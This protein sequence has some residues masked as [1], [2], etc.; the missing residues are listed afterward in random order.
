MRAT[1]VVAMI[2]HAVADGMPPALLVDLRVLRAKVPQVDAAAL[3]EVQ[4]YHLA[5]LQG[6]P[7]E[8]AVGGC[9]VCAPGLAGC[10]R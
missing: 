7:E 1:A 2:R 6:Q 10:Q 9:G 3:E 4:V 8:Q 5:Q